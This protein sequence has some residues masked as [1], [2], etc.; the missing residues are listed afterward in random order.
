QCRA[1]R[2]P[3]RAA[4]RAESPALAAEGDELLGVAVLAA[5]AQ[6]AVLEATAL[7]IRRELLLHVL[8]QRPARRFA[9]RDEFGVVALDELVEQR[10]LGTV[11]RVPGRIDERRRTRPCSPLACHGLASLRWID[12]TTLSVPGR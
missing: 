5:H 7:Q 11:A 4:R 9:R 6:K 10:R 12:A 2:H 8:R 3:S 1:V